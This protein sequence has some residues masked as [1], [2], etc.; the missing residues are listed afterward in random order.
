MEDFQ[1]ARDKARKHVRIADHMLTQTYPLIN[2]PKLLITVANNIFIACSS[3]M[4]AILYYERLFKRI[5]NFVD[6]FENKFSIFTARCMRR[7]NMSDRYIKLIKDVKELLE[8]RKNAPVEFARKDKFIIC[9]DNYRT[10]TI[11]VDGL[12]KYV[13]EAKIFISDMERMVSKNEHIFT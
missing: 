8:E 4:S 11:S 9:S 7:Y 3:A 12:K 2:D 5:P 1:V 10:R 13:E 6:N